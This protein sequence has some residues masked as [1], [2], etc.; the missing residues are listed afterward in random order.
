MDR[1]NE[2]RSSIKRVMREWHARIAASSDSI[3]HVFI[4]DEQCDNYM[5]LDLGWNKYE[6]VD[7]IYIYVRIHENKIRV[8]VDWTEYGIARELVENGVAKDDIVLAFHR[9][10]KRPYTE[11]AVA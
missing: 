7:G 4:C 5:L 10:E 1:I 8:E 9:P 11:F 6:R 3:E 2:Y